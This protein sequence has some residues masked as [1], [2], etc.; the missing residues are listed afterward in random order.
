MNSI[1]AVIARFQ[2]MRKALGTASRAREH[3]HTLEFIAFFFQQLKQECGLRMLLNMVSSLL[4]HCC[5]PA[6][7][8]YFNQMRLFH[9]RACQLLDA[10]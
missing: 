2:N 10:R 3:E 1:H 4:N 6:A 5:R 7:L 8:I 9:C